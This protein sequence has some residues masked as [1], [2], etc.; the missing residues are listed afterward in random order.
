MRLWIG[1][2]NS[3]SGFYE[4]KTIEGKKQPF[5]ITAVDGTLLTASSA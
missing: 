1:T 2:M 3:S 5:Y 4:W